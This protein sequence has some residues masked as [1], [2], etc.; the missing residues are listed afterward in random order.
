MCN[1]SK[2]TA[3]NKGWRSFYSLNEVRI[4][5]IAQQNCY[6]SAHTKVFYTEWFV[7]KRDA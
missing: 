2:R 1:V 4:E 3:M 6:G 5:C 7:V